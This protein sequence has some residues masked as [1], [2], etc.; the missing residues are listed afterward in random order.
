[1]LYLFRCNSGLQWNNANHD[2]LCALLQVFPQI[3]GY[4]VQRIQ[5]RNQSE[6]ICDPHIVMQ[7]TQ[8]KPHLV[9]HLTVHNVWTMPICFYMP[10]ESQFISTPLLYTSVQMH[11]CWPNVDCLCSVYH[12]WMIFSTLTLEPLSVWMWHFC[13]AF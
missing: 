13:Y 11:T 9:P 1:M 3:F 10:I 8:P 12:H 4:L 5:G 2:W 7:P 6:Q